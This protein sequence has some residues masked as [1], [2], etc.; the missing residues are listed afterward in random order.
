M[1]FNG[2]SH[3]HRH[4]SVLGGLLRVSARAA[5]RAANEAS[6]LPWRSSPPRRRCH[7]EEWPAI[8][9]WP[10]PKL[11]ARC[12][13]RRSSPACSLS[14]PGTVVSIAWRAPRASAFL[15]TTTLVSALFATSLLGER[16]MLC[17]VGGAC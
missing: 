13:I 7:W 4:D 9:C 15:H 2:G 16:G 12:S 1:R 3:H 11:R 17:Q 6:G 14:S 5:G 10:L 8:P